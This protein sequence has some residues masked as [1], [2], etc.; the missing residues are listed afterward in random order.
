VSKSYA[1]TIPVP[2]R[3]GILAEVGATMGGALLIAALARIVVPLPFSPVPVTGQTLGVLLVGLLLGSRQGA[4]SVVS[5]ILL[6]ISGIPVFALGAGPVYLV[7]PTGGY[8]L[9]FIGAAFLVG[10]VT[11]QPWGRS[12][13]AALLALVVGTAVIYACGLVWLARFTGLTRVLR[14][15]LFPFLLGDS[16]K[17]TV[18]LAA[19]RLMLL[20]RR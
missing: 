9:G 19:A 20:V 4:A 14:L 1:V 17:L 12:Q 6:G 2:A 13:L 5:Y 15:G 16:I 11:E 8:L 3:T 7:G 18:A 10:W